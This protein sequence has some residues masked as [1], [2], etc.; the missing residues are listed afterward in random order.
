VTAPVTGLEERKAL[1]RD[2]F[3]SLDGTSPHAVRL[4]AGALRVAGPPL[5]RFSSPFDSHADMLEHGLSDWL[6]VLTMA[7]ALGQVAAFHP[8]VAARLEGLE[9]PP[10]PQL[11][12]ALRAVDE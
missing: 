6:A 10:W 4:L 5:A 2:V 3:R 8:E 1:A 11:L 7:G 12:A 9:A